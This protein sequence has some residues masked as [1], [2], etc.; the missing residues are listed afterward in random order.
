MDHRDAVL[1]VFSTI[2][3]TLGGAF[4]ILAAFV[5]YR[6]QSDMA[7]RERNAQTLVELLPGE[8]KPTAWR[9]LADNRYEE[10]LSLLKGEPPQT[11]QLYAFI[12][13]KASVEG[14][15]A[16][17]KL[18]AWAAGSTALTVVFC[19]LCLKDVNRLAVSALGSALLLVAIGMTALSFGSYFMLIW[20]LLIDRRSP[21]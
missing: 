14:W 5:L 15:P 4:G 16:I 20:P 13:F 3:Q 18:F 6:F 12:K 2:P 19:L 9:Y 11:I 1:Y 17:R 21:R 7:T 8:H 10:F